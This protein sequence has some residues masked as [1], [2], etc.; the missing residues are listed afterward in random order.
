M[1]KNVRLNAKF[2]RGVQ[3]VGIG[4]RSDNLINDTVRYALCEG[5]DASFTLIHTTR[6][7]PP[8]EIAFK[9]EYVQYLKICS[10]QTEEK[11]QHWTAVFNAFTIEAFA[12]DHPELVANRIN[13]DDAFA[14]C[15]ASIVNAEN[16]AEEYSAMGTHLFSLQEDHNEAEAFNAVLQ[17]VTVTA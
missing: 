15:L 12:E 3:L 14:Q 10:G 11:M 5:D 17:Y 2:K 9:P 13:S 8:V 16:A 6:N 4:D 1:G 7:G